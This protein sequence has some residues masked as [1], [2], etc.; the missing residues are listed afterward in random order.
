MR[1]PREIAFRLRQETANLWLYAFPPRLNIDAPAPIAKL[2]D[3][4]G[5]F[6]ALAGSPLA[7]QIETLAE[8]FLAHRFPVLGINIETGPEI[9]WSRDYV[10]GISNEVP[11]F[12]R[13]KYLDFAAVGD[14]KIIWELNRHQHLVI[15]AQAWLLTRRDDFLKEIVRQLEHWLAVNPFQ[16]GIN[17][18]SALE[19]GFRALS[20]I[21]VYHFAGSAFSPEFRQ[22]FL[23]AIYRH[24]LHLNANLSVYFSPNTHLLGEAVA[25]HAIA[26]AFPD[27]PASGGWRR[28]AARIVSEE[29]DRQVRDDG[30]HFEQSSYY[31]VYAVDFFALHAIL[32]DTDERYRSKLARMTEYLIALLGPERRLVFLGDDDGGRLFHPYGPRDTFGRGTVALCSVLLNRPEWLTHPEDLYEIALWWLGPKVLA[33]PAAPARQ[34]ASRF[35]PDA[36]VAVLHRGRTQVIVDAGPFGVWG[37]GHSHSDTLSMTVRHGARDML[38]DPGTYTYISSPIWRSRF[39]GTAA[40]NTIRVQNRDQATPVNAFRWAD[41]PETEVLDWSPSGRIDAICRY[42]DIR[43][44]RVVEFLD[45]HTLCVLDV[46]ETLDP[47]L[48]AEQFWHP[49]Q[50]LSQLSAQSFDLGDGVFLCLGGPESPEVSAGGDYGWRSPALG[51]KEC[52]PLIVVTRHGSGTL[53]FGAALR[54]DA[55]PVSVHVEAKDEGWRVKLLDGSEVVAEMFVPSA[56]CAR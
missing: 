7:R 9:D 4:D 10:H 48:L 52:S 24:G 51:A 18:A 14:H 21:Y 26:V 12:R 56:Y 25:L 5:V 50:I 20:W 35:F 38:I 40:H 54:F 8:G 33:M 42:S 41:K 29:M 37:A 6:A 13:V 47:K 34:P 53:V 55:R 45:T 11:Y 30:S 1:S 16:C 43:H 2:P 36:G 27:L 15:L 19:V 31:H 44:R 49:G 22:R 23:L 46:V 28:K 17:W 39:R 3:P 32:E